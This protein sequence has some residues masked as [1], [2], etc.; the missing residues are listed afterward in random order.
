MF[1]DDQLCSNEA[2]IDC[3][4]T[5]CLERKSQ[6]IL[7]QEMMLVIS[8]V[9][10]IIMTKPAFAQ[11]FCIILISRRGKNSRGGEEGE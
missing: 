1:V 5:L 4:F 3:S 6:A 7:T 9:Y 2:K 11:K 10:S 8:E